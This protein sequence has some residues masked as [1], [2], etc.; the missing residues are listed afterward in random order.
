MFRIFK[1]QS[2]VYEKHITTYGRI[3]GLST[4]LTALYNLKP[5][6]KQET[7]QPDI[8]ISNSRKTNRNRQS[9]SDYRIFINTNLN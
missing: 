4:Y 1:E 5:N 7:S 9:N 2:S 8:R 6:R 3:T